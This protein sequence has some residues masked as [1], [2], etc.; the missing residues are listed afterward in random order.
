MTVLLL[1]NNVVSI[2]FNRNHAPHKRCVEA[3][4]GRQLVMS[5][6]TRAELL[7][8]PTTNKWGSQ[9]RS[10]LEQHMGLYLALP[11]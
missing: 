11:G 2:L 1:D 4:A 5:F 3:V 10:A 9:R 7:L 8:W 6:M